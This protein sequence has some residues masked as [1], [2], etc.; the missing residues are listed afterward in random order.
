M[1]NTNPGEFQYKFDN[2]IS[3]VN[4]SLK[5]NSINSKDYNLKVVNVPTINNFEMILSYP[6]YLKRKTEVI[7]GT[8][9]AIVPEGTSIRW[10]LSTFATTN[11]AFILNNSKS[12][13]SSTN[14]EF[15]FTKNISQNTEYQIVTSN[16]N[17]K[18]FEKLDYQVNIVKDQYPFI[19]ANKAPDS[20]SLKKNFIIVKISL[21]KNIKNLPIPYQIFKVNL[22]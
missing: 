16:K 14:G 1:E 6:T 19:A 5:A 4:F 7:K 2:V 17:V 10:K 13:Y 12:V 3:D 22:L 9:N 15:N 21:E 11:I 8:G 20:L 18:N